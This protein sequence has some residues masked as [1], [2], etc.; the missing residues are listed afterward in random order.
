VELV[1]VKK[2]FSQFSLEASHAGGYTQTELFPGF[3]D[4][5]FEA[6]FRGAFVGSRDVASVHGAGPGRLRLCEQ[7]VVFELGCSL[8]GLGEWNAHPDHWITVPDRRR[9]RE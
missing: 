6:T 4:S 9:G 8:Q 5:N 3:W 2:F 7:P 1:E